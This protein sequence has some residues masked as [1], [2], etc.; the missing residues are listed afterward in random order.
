MV[1]TAVQI[2]EERIEAEVAVGAKLI[3]N[4]ADPVTSR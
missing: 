1:V 3:G 4:A 2:A